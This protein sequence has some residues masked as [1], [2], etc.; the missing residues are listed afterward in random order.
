MEKKNRA[1][2]SGIHSK[3]NGFAAE[4]YLAI[5][6]S[7]RRDGRAGKTDL[8]DGAR[9]IESKFFTIKPATAKKNAEYNSAHGFDATKD[10]PLLEQLKRYCNKFDALVIGWGENPENAEYDV[11]TRK[12]AYEFLA[13]RLQNSTTYGIRFCWGGKSL[14]SRLEGRYN[15]LRKNGYII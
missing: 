2:E 12:E 7:M 4:H 14:E 8:F 5:K 11:L 1:S 15:T 6:N 9:R 3:N 13:K 10:K